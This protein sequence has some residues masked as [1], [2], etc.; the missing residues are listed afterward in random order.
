MVLRKERNEWFCGRNGEPQGGAEK[1]VMHSAEG[2][3][4]PA[5]GSRPLTVCDGEYLF[6]MN[7]PNRDTPGPRDA[8]KDNADGSLDPYLRKDSPGKG[9][10][11][12]RPPAP[13]GKFILMLRP[14]WPRETSPSI[15]NG[16]RQPPAVRAAK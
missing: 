6:V 4:P 14:Y 13:S 8:L 1:Y 11:S 5:R 10:G 7:P 2:Q 12:D 3:T 15:I 16:A 9:K